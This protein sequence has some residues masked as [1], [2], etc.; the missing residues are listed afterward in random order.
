MGRLFLMSDGSAL[1]NASF[2]CLKC[3]QDGRRF[4]RLLHLTPDGPVD[5]HFSMKWRGFD[6]GF[7]T[8]PNGDIA[9]A[10]TLM[11]RCSAA[12]RVDSRFQAI[13][14]GDESRAWI[15]QSRTWIAETF[16]QFNRS[17]QKYLARI[18]A[19]EQIPE[20]AL[21]GSF[22]LAAGC[23]LPSPTAS[24]RWNSPDNSSPRNG[25][26]CREFSTATIGRRFQIPCPISVRTHRGPGRTP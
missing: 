3:G 13:A 15:F 4:Q 25:H 18:H 11:S 23:T 5:E 1:L 24:T 16:A 17:P 8:F 19:T 21:G 6:G 9:I 7:D 14:P 20:N 12:G 2:S 10:G 26:P 22:V